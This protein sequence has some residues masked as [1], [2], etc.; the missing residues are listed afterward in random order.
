MV[1]RRKA[2]RDVP[3]FVRLTAAR[4]IAVVIAVAVFIFLI[5]S[6]DVSLAKRL[7]LGW[8]GAALT[9]L[10]LAWTTIFR[11]DAELTHMRAREYDQSGFAIFLLVLAAA[12]ASVVAITIV[13]ADVKGLS[14]WARLAHL[15]MSV[16]ALV[17]SW[18]LIQT[19]FTFHY[20]HQY[21]IPE[22]GED[23]P[24]GGLKF[25]GG[26]EPAYLDFAYYAFVIGMT[27]QVSDVAVTGPHMRRTAL[28]HGVLSFIFN[29]A[30]LA[31]SINV[32]SSIL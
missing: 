20:A 4:R 24:R 21:Y 9:Y 10:A 27:S 7:L 11:T 25:P 2:D 5:Q 6:N 14:T 31:L 22:E 30:V 23:E 16:G 1:R 8:D 13:V 29:I 15:A 26:E 12:C 17:L 3:W 18:M 19:L 32:F 28:A